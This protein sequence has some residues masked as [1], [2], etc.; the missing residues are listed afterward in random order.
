MRILPLLFFTLLLSGCSSMNPIDWFADEDNSEPP[1]ELVE[2]EDSVS[3]T[4]RWSASISD[5]A[6]EQ[7]VKLVPYVDKGRV[8]AASRNGEVRALDA[9][10]GRPLWSRDTELEISGGPGAGEGLVLVGTSNG[11]VLALDE[12]D[13]SEKWR[14]RVSSEILSVPK[15]S[16]GV[17]VVHTIDGKLF[18]LDAASGKQK[19][20]YDRTIPVLTLHG[21]SSPVIADRRVIC[22]FA[23]GKLAMLDLGTGDLLWEVSVSAPSGR[24]ELERM[25]DIDG[26]PLVL[27]D[28][29]YVVTYQGEMAAVSL[30]T[31]IVLWRRQLSSYAGMGADYLY[32]YV[33]DDTD[34][35]LAVDP[36]NGAA[37][38]KNK[39][40]QYR[41]LTAPVLLGGY[42]VVA[43]FEG[44]LHLLSREDGKLLG[45]LRVA[46]S[47]ITTPPIVVADVAYIY[48]EGG[49]M[50]AVTVSPR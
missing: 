30:E 48:A 43:D 7:R 14:A 10:S 36:G 39:K 5:G 18:G 19:W 23:S 47:A 20:L 45:R 8:Y 2:M 1:A 13:G 9:E 12:N 33:S 27:D 25:V 50:V 32:L 17:V 22:G 44:Y 49:E 41:K 11:E 21:S 26:D 35:V 16:Y 4:I 38:W 29:V 34:H 15:A 31:G 24:S 42:V 28:V 46:K 40:L 3:A 37:L 6:D